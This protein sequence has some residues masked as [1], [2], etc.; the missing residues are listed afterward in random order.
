MS[1]EIIVFDLDETLLSIDVS[2]VWVEYMVKN[3]M[4]SDV[5]SFT[6]KQL[7]FEQLYSQASAYSMQEYVSFSL[8][9]II[10]MDFKELS[11][12][13]D[14]FVE[15]KI[16]SKVYQ[17]GKDLVQDYID[18]GFD[19]LLISASIDNLVRPVGKYI[20]F[21]DK[22]IIAIDIA[23]HNQKVVGESSGVLSFGVGKLT[24]LK[25]WSK[26]NGIAIDNVTFYSDS[27]NDL[28]LLKYAKRPIATNPS[29]DLE[30]FAKNEGWE[31]IRF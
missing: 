22:N 23:Y 4:V 21:D 12:H 13:I 26:D 27:M 17:Q 18:K 15:Q 2:D 3:G 28:P 6:Q 30:S 14:R 25:A 29:K 20:G 5:K 24:R 8:Q 31:I 10:G 11:Q 9:P 7:E 19:V 1:K 16:V